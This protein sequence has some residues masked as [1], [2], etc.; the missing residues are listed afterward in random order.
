MKQAINES[1]YEPFQNTNTQAALRMMR[2]QVFG[3]PADR[4]FV[5]NLAIVVT[6][7]QST[8]NK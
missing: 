8:I 7:G 6:D 3:T 1:R 5:L 4:D 2:T